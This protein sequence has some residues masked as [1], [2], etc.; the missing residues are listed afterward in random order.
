MV[1]A[2]LVGQRRGRIVAADLGHDQT[3]MT[4]P[5]LGCAH[6]QGQQGRRAQVGD[7]NVG[8]GQEP[9]GHHAAAGQPKVE[10]DASPGAVVHLEARVDPRRVARLDQAAAPGRV[11]A[12]WLD[13]DHVRAPVGQHCGARRAGREAADLDD[14]DAEQRSSV[15]LA[16]I[17][18]L[19]C[20]GHQPSVDGGHYPRHYHPWRRQCW[21][22]APLGLGIP[23][24]SSRRAS[25]GRRP[26]SVSASVALR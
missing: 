21:T 22:A 7:Q 11:A 16:A 19:G 6:R 12:R 14:P 24:C 25:P 1:V 10:D 23:R 17:G 20:F 5:Q 18:A 3:R 15:P 4:G 9:V 26:S 13:L 2:A 8:R